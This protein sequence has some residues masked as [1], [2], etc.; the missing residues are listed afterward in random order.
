MKKRK[1]KT[2]SVS[3]D[4]WFFSFLIMVSMFLLLN[5]FLIKERLF[6][7]N[8]QSY[9]EK[10]KITLTSLYELNNKIFTSHLSDQ[11]SKFYSFSSSDLIY[12][13]Q[14]NLSYRNYLN[15]AFSQVS[16]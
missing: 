4:Y 9:L 1:Y 11:N 10:Y 15:N 14:T 13:P 5:L 7:K 6:V 12:F 2:L 3:I 8:L 16:Y